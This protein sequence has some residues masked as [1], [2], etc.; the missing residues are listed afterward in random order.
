MKITYSRWTDNSLRVEE[1]LQQLLDLFS[2]LLLRVNADVI[3]ALDIFRHLN[4]QYDMLGDMTMDEFIELLRSQGYLEYKNGQYAASKKSLRKLRNDAFNEIFR[5]L[6]KSGVGNHETPFA[7]QGNERLP[8]IRNYQFGDSADII[9]ITQTI[10]NALIRNSDLSNFAL[11][12][13]DVKVYETEH[14]GSCATVLMIDISH[15]MIL[16][17]EDRIT[18]AKQVALALAEF[19]S[20]KFPKDELQAILFGDEARKVSL[21]DIPFISVGPFHT[22]TLDGLKLS[23]GIL[24]K[25]R[26]S[27]KQI[28]MI[29]DG[30]PSA[31]FDENGRLFKNPYGLDT[32]IVNK[33]LDEAVACRR[34]GITISVFMLASDNYLVDFI[35]NLTKAN[36]GRAFYTGLNHLGEALFVDYISNRRKHFRG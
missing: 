13:D 25:M 12:A 18:P 26:G 9:D 7:G 16:Y 1:S 20:I 28:F 36:H 30:K 14:L 17:G 33:T 11:C 3:T 24:R 15:S 22:N 29:T 8:E 23:R 34:D 5:S 2:S 6:K 10:S 19:I 35:E 32:R 21:D 27:N 4:E 31:I